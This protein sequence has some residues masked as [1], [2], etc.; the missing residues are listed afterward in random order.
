L[1]VKKVFFLLT[2]IINQSEFSVL[3]EMR[4]KWILAV[5]L[6]ALVPLAASEGVKATENL[7]EVC[8]LVDGIRVCE[9]KEGDEERKANAKVEPNVAAAEAQRK[10]EELRKKHEPEARRRVEQMRKE[11]QARKAKEEKLEKRMAEAEE[12]RAAQLKEEKTRFAEEAARK[13]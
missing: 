7:S 11:E 12:T 5:V 3:I 8:S 1:E 2:R 6:L 4:W 9:Q 10:E 13:G